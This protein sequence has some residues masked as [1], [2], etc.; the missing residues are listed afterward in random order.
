MLLSRT[1]RLLLTEEG[2]ITSNAWTGGPLGGGPV[3]AA[4]LELQ[5]QGPVDPS[6]GYLCDIKI[7]DTVLGHAVAVAGLP[8]RG[9]FL[10]LRAVAESIQHGDLPAPAQRLRLM[11][12]NG[13]ALTIVL[14]REALM[15]YT[16]Q[17]EFS[18]AH[19]LHVDGLPDEQNRALF[20]KCN[21]PNGHGHNYVVE[22]TVA[23]PAPATEGSSAARRL[24]EVVKREVIDRYDHRHLNLDVP[25]FSRL[26]PT[27][28]NI[29][30]KVFERLSSPD[31]LGDELV[32]VRVHE[33]AKTW[34]E[35]S[36]EHAGSAAPAGR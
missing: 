1:T 29:T 22:V 28:E 5:L 11:L 4:D 7:I 2:S 20:G 23:L 36:R 3:W 35:V 9:W 19:R 10:W 27:V 17:F 34:A 31:L 12:G 14:S 18:A 8:S 26:N 25:D 33:T 32:S 6:S 16:E 21:N 15:H 13:I 30:A 24:S